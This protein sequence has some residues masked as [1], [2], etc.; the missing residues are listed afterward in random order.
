MAFFYRKPNIAPDTLQKFTATFREEQLM[1][2]K[3]INLSPFNRKVTY[4]AGCDSSLMD[5]KILSVFVVLKYDTMEVIETVFNVG[6]LLIPYIPGFLAFREIPNLLETF[7]KLTI[8]P[9][10]IMVDGN[11]IIHPLKMGIATHLGIK[12]S[13]PTLG[14]AKHKLVGTYENPAENKGAVKPL[15]YK[16]EQLGYALR[17]K[18]KTNPIFVSPG[19]LCSLEDSLRITVECLRKHKLPEPTRLADDYSKKLKHNI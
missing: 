3:H 12:L 5:D 4:I 9:D 8:R 15:H 6:P 10:I 13:I 19:H 18:V 11:G 16:N 14:V 17:S 7:K 1:L 2:A